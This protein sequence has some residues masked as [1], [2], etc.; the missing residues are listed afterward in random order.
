MGLKCG[1]KS[2]ER[3]W[4]SGSQSNHYGIEIKEAEKR[5]GAEIASQ[6]N[7]YGIEIDYTLDSIN[8]F[9]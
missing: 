7:H 4:K 1:D 5:F 9:L 2:E 3:N 6:S 8:A